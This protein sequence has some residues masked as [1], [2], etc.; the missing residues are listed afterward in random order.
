MEVEW[1]ILADAAQIAGGKLYLMGGG[2]DQINVNK[3]PH[4]QNMAIAVSFK[5]P[6]TE[7]NLKHNF[8]IEIVGGDGGIITS[9]PGQFEV[10]R[11][12]GLPPGQ[13]QRAQ[14]VVNVAWTIEWNGSYVIVAHIDGEEDRR[15]PFNVVPGPISQLEQ[16]GQA[17]PPN[18]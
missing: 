4:P 13:D 9:V 5:V 17:P 8:K 11:P 2:W 12:A 1:L 3:F 15:F 10:G 7:T 14:M 18:D 16:Q 6:W